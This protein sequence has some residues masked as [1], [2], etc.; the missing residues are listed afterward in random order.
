MKYT[1]ASTI[2]EVD[3]AETLQFCE[4]FYEEEI[5]Q[6]YENVSFYWKVDHSGTV[7]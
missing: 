6:V 4:R 5:P 1:E 2:K 7:I 3:I